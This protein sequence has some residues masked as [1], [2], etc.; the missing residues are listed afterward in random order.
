MKAMLCLAAL[1]AACSDDVAPNATVLSATPDMLTMSDD[2]ANDLT[3][4]VQY[5]DGDGDLGG[6]VAEVHDCRSD[7]YETMFTIPDLV[8][9]KEHITGKIDLYLNDVGPVPADALPATCSQL[10]VKALGDGQ[11]VFCVVL[12]DV[13]GHRGSGSC[14]PVISLLP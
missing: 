10:G 14:T 6:G 12:V 13:A 4:T 9:Q 5:D 7:T 11:A 1:L 2:S 8:A 3:I